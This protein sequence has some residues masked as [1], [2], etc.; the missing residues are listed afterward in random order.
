M[1]QLEGSP[2]HGLRS[3]TANREAPAP[4]VRLGERDNVVVL[5]RHVDAGDSFAGPSGEIWTMSAHLGVGNKLAAV[6][7]AAGDR[8]FKVGVPIGTATKAIQSGE[9]VHSHN[10]R[11]D[12]IP[13][14][15]EE[16]YGEHPGA[17]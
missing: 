1:A 11:S 12:H 6:P 14:E 9:H 10:L 2:Q 8:V 17:G 7:I 5:A 4:Y 3:A 13:I 15:L 16:E